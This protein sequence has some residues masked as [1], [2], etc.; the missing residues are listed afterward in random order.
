MNYSLKNLFRSVGKKVIQGIFR[1]TVIVDLIMQMGG[2]GSTCIAGQPN[3]I[4]ALNLL[5]VLR[6]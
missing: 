1:R 2:S 5:P 3:N 4:T 6:L